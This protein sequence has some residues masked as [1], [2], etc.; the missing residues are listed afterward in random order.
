MTN[1]LKKDLINSISEL[2]NYNNDFIGSRYDNDINKIIGIVNNNNDEICSKCDEI[3]DFIKL[4]NTGIKNQIEMMNNNLLENHKTIHSDLSKLVTA[5]DNYY[6]ESRKYFFNGYESVLNEVM[7][8][9]FLF[10]LCYFNNIEFL[11]F[12]PKKIECYLR[13]VMILF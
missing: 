12:S 4:D 3:V 1:P 8:T 13:L 11:S 7:D 2:V 5:Y 10:N 9:D 6:K